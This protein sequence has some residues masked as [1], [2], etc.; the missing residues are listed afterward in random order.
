PEQNV[1]KQE[2]VTAAEQVQQFYDLLV[3]SVE[4]IRQFADKVP[5]FARV[6]PKKTRNYC[7]TRVWSSFLSG[8][9]IRPIDEKFTFCNGTVL[10]REQCQQIFGDWL[11]TILDF[12]ASLHSMDIDIS[13]FACLCALALVTERHGLK[14][15]QRVEQLQMKIIGSLRDHVTLQ[16]RSSE[17]ATLLQPH[18]HP[19]ARAEDPQR[20]GTATHLLPG[21]WKTSYRHPRWSRT[22][23][24]PACPS[25]RPTV[26]TSNR[27]VVLF[28][29]SSGWLAGCENTHGMT[30]S[31]PQAG[32]PKKTLM[33]DLPAW[34]AGHD[35]H[36]SLKET[37]APC[38]WSTL[39]RTLLDLRP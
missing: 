6:S 30:R 11:N 17:E 34:G 20:P 4:V 38:E 8:Y 35:P 14:E 18:P 24:P 1:H 39:R 2:A 29:R 23:S 22:S 36:P 13:A 5:G 16:Q 26:R 25:K 3:S 19:A 9:R 7:S 10:S 28:A 31:Q 27:P 32:L 37:F 15:P 21:G 12:S 33:G